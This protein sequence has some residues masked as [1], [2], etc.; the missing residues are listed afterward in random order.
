[1]AAS[2]SGRA[3]ELLG[4]VTPTSDAVA[5]QP[6]ANGRRV[7]I[8][9]HQGTVYTWDVRPEQWIAF[10]CRLAG[11]D[12]TASEWTGVFGARHQVRLCPPT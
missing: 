12:L 8:A 4:T 9:N 10:G 7:L 2:A 11:R 5:A 3:G 6:M 1:M